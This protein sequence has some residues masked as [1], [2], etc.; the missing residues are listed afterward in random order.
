MKNINQ[1]GL[2]W[3]SFFSYA[4]TGALIVVTGMIMG[5][6][7]A[8]FNLSISQMSNIFTCLNAGILIS[9]LLNSWLIN[10]F[11]LKNY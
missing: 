8:Y 6:I 7:A 11:S 9:I 2:T 5:D 3:I 10:I 1:I 4:F